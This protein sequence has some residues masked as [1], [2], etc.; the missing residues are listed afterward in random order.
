MTNLS[1]SRTVSVYATNR[2]NPATG[3]GKME[4]GLI[5]GLEAAGVK[6]AADAP[7]GILTGSPMW[8]VAYGRGKRL[9][10]FTMSETNR[11][12]RD[13]VKVLNGRFEVC[14]VPSPDLVKVYVDSGVTIP[15]R[16]VPLGVDFTPIPFVQRDPDAAKNAT[17]E[18]PF[19]FLTY[20]LGDMR[21]G[22]ELAM[23]A[24]N[25]LFGGDMRYRM[26]VKCRDNP[27]WLAGL[28]DPQIT[29]MRGEQ[30]EAEWQAL[31][32]KCHVG[33]FPSRGE[34]FGLPPREWTLAGLPTVATRW[35]GMW[36]VSEWGM[37]LGVRELRT[38]QFEYYEANAEGSQWGEPDIAQL[39]VWMKLIVEDYPAALEIAKHGREYLL[40]KFTWER[41]GKD[42]NALM[43][44]PFEAPHCPAPALGKAHVAF[45]LGS[46]NPGGGETQICHLANEVKARGYDV[47][48]ILPA[49]G[50]PLAAPLNDWLQAHGI[51]VVSLTSPAER[52]LE[53]LTHILGVM[54]P[55]MVIACG[56][57]VML[58][59]MLAAYKAGVKTRVANFVSMGLEREEFK[60]D[61]VKEFAG[62]KA[63]THLV[64]NSEAVLMSLPQYQG[65]EMLNRDIM[66]GQVI[67]NGVDV[68]EVTTELR[69]KAREYWKLSENDVAIGYLAHFRKDGIKNQMML[70]N[71][72][73]QVLKMHPNATFIMAGY[74]TE[75]AEKCANEIERLGL[76]ERVKMPG[77]LDDVRMI[78]GW[79][80]AVNCSKTEGFSNAIQEAMAYGLPHVVTKV[81]GNPE[82]VTKNTG[83]LVESDAANNMTSALSML[84]SSP[85]LRKMWGQEAR[86]T[87]QECY[88]W[89][90]V[91]KQWLQ[92]LN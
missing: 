18:D 35:L 5:R 53:R 81:G 50:G 77:R 19:T 74:H 4:L 59:A 62:I 31:M 61:W 37:A 45:V 89:E 86:R 58:D 15:V 49:G 34:G 36:D 91:V 14:L 85:T 64:G 39:D 3:Y 75:Y 33:L 20:S 7:V 79:D 83:Y 57:P 48:I 46:L 68:P 67:H 2:A 51:P 24:F 42:I 73:D 80:I 56:Y 65:Y 47:S 27:M 52:W 29:I 71:V 30:S 78:A 6:V 60:I 40:E 12:S 17:P 8:H 9:W 43:T 10:A 72:A 82:L 90:T 21:K 32:A 38:A 28:I 55:D 22:A 76:S 88:G 26:I 66:R 69:Q 41:V 44:P 25:R 16:Y 92:L 23:F 54:K 63:A 1:P 70:I 11:V 13:W 87:M 84:I